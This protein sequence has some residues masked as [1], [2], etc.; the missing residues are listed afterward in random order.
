MNA[1]LAKFLTSHHGVYST[2][3]GKEFA[4][5][6]RD[7]AE[8]WDLFW[9]DELIELNDCGIEEKHLEDAKVHAHARIDYRKGCTLK[10]SQLN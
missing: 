10:W 1:E 4:Y 6:G 2:K 5:I 9:K 8:R 7:M 3:H